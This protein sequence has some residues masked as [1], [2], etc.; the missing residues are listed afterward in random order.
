[1][2][3]ILF[4]FNIAMMKA[5]YDDALFDDFKSEVDRLHQLAERSP[6]F[7]WRYPGEKDTDGYI[8]PYHDDPL[9][10]GNMSAWRDYDSLFKY[11]FDGEHLAIMRKKR[12]WFN[13]LSHP[14]TVLYYGVEQDLSKSNEELLEEAK[15]RLSYLYRHGESSV[16]FGFGHH[17]GIL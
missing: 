14:W 7:V 17:R 11:S 1:M 15:R 12:K 10:M 3:R 6:G 5:S 8:K 4:Q 13:T 9:V 2:S 16:A